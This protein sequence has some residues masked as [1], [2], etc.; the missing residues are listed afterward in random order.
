MC[1][2][3]GIARRDGIREPLAILRNARDLLIHRGPDRAGEYSSDTV[4]LGFRRL[5]IIDLSPHGDQPMSDS[6][7]NTWVVF[8]GEIYNFVELREELERAG[9]FFRGRSDTEVLLHLYMVYGEGMLEKLNGMFAIAV[10]DRRQRTILLGRDRMGKKPLFYWIHDG[11]LAFASE[12]RA[13]RA[14]PGFPS[15]TDPLALALYLRLGWIPGWTCIHPGVAKL[16][17]ATWLRYQVQTGGVDGPHAYWDLPK[18][19][20]DEGI[21]VDS[22]LD[23]IQEKLW[24]ATRIR[25]RSDVPLGTFLS[26]GI[27]SSLVTAAAAGYDARNLTAMT[28]SFPGWADNEWPLAEATAKHLGVHA[29]HRELDADSASLLPRVMGHFDEPFA[30][31]SALPTA[32]IC[33]TAREE[34]TVALSGDGGDELFAGYENHVRALSWAELDRVSSGPAKSIANA[35]AC[36][37]PPDSRSR[38]FLRRFGYPVATLGLGGKLYPFE[39]W[40]DDCIADEYRLTHSETGRL[41]TEHMV[42]WEGS[43]PLDR[44]QRTDMRLY[45]ADD[46]L[47]K[48]DRMSMRH[49]LEVRSPF[50]DYRMVELALRIP[51]ELR[52]HGGQN[53]YL[54][55]LLAGRHVPKEVVAAPKRGFGI[56][57]RQW[58]FASKSTTW[59][60]EVATMQPTTPLDPLRPGGGKLLWDKAERNPALVPALF[61][62]L[63]YRW[64]QQATGAM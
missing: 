22:W 50:L 47:V 42:E 34:M 39:D 25:L 5:S 31:S 12:L 8:N 56:P 59:L 58:L 6:D 24:D 19:H 21:P 37:A 26:G 64:W 36:M 40:L 7:G 11:G 1:G 29:V 20:L 3:V 16:P 18:I 30:D 63:S 41:L 44:A 60:K 62:I 32:L 4:Y 14:L 15:G 2:I 38:R 13:L 61:R 23:R 35:L 45:M 10:Y 48:V 57:L 27:D 52:V 55:R 51:P 9:H 33:Q 17:P 54:L 53:K 49:S 46:I 43:H 28:I